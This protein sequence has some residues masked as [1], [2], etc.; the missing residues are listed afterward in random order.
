MKKSTRLALLF[1]VGMFSLILSSCNSSDTPSSG[2]INMWTWI[3][4][5]DTVNANGTYNGMGNPG[6][7]AARYR[8]V[9]WFDRHQSVAF[10][11]GG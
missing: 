3:N 6:T 4:G 1:L 10:R 2:S 11:G 7:P 9:S 8:S 5:S